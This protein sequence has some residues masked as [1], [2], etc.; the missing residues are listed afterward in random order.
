M[1]QTKVHIYSLAQGDVNI[2]A[3]CHKIVWRHLY[4]LDILQNT[5]LIYYVNDIQLIEQDK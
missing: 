2:P 1:K 3:L 4:L 5:M